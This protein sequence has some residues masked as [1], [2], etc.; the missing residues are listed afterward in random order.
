M[1]TKE[2]INLVFLIDQMAIGGTEKQLIEIINLLNKKL[3]NIFLVCL[4]DSDYL[5]N[6]H[7]DCKQKIFPTSSLLS[8]NGIRMLFRFINFLKEENI[9][10]LQTFFIDSNIFGVLAGRFAGIKKIIISRRDLG[11]WYTKK[12]LY[13]LRII[14]KL[15]CRYV[16]NSKAVKEVVVKYERIKED[17][18]DIIY[19]GISLKPFESKYNIK[20]IKSELK[21]PETDKI[22]GIVSNLNRPVKRVDIFISASAFV[23]KKINNTSFIIVGEGYL[24]NEL[25]Q[26]AED[27]NI[28]NKIHF[29]GSQ[30]NIYPYLQLFD[31][32][33]LTSET[34]GFS[35]SILEYLAAGLPVVCTNSGGN[36]EIIRNGINGYLV[37]QNEPEQF[38]NAIIKLLL[39]RNK[40][41]VIKNN[42]LE[43]INKFSLENKKRQLN[44]YYLNVS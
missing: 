21:I 7:L 20:K 6:I 27:L 38:A 9:D 10:I 36:T 22:V 42:N 31:I 23:L 12:L 44:E 11:F 37:E 2:K 40:V 33:A 29:V 5:Q 34:E 18:I 35:N 28:K 39:D 14:N 32:G 4:R 17:R 24:K 19:N 8:I 13:L 1:I 25:M 16:V 30:D 15:N 26:L 3:Y 43:I 41:S